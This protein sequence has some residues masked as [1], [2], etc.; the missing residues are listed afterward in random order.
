[1]A[2][3][4]GALLGVLVGRWLSFAGAP[5]V[6]VVALVVVDMVTQAAL[7]ESSTPV[8]R[9]WAPWI[10]WHG[11]TETNHTATLYAGNAAFSLVYLLCLCAAAIIG[12]LWH[13]RAARG[14]QLKRAFVA[15]VVVGLAALALSMT[16]GDTHNHVSPPATE[17]SA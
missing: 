17:R 16:T 3:F 5:A 8:A 14:P 9:L 10:M 11:G 15:T 7:A 4:G 13:D 6:M 2:C 12:A 1:V